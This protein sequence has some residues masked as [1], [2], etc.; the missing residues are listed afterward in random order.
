[1]AFKWPGIRLSSSVTAFVIIDTQMY[2]IPA[3]KACLS[4]S[5]C[6]DGGDE[7]TE[8][9]LQANVEDYVDQKLEVCPLFIH[10]HRW[11]LNPMDQLDMV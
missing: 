8:I 6:L 1:M 3:F 2:I 11:R 7:L 9:K 5:A 10:D 4:A